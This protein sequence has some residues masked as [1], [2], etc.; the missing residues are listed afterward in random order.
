[1][2]VRKAK[3]PRVRATWIPA[4]VPSNLL[5]PPENKEVFSWQTFAN[6]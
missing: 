3:L 6:S 1:M 4:H 5:E 2:I